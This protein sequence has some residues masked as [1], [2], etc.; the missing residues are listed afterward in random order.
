MM[1]KLAREKWEKMFLKRIK[2]NTPP[3]R[4]RLLNSLIIPK[5]DQGLRILNIRVAHLILLSNNNNSPEKLV[6]KS[7]RINRNSTRCPMGIM[8]TSL[9]ERSLMLHIS[10]AVSHLK[11]WTLQSLRLWSL[12]HLLN[13]RNSLFRM[14]KDH[15]IQGHP[16]TSKIIHS[17]A[18]KC[19][20]F[21]LLLLLLSHNRILSRTER[22]WG[23]SS[24]HNN[25]SKTKVRC[26]RYPASRVRCSLSWESW[27]NL[28]ARYTWSR[29]CRTTSAWLFPSSKTCKSLGHLE[30]FMSIMID[31]SRFSSA[32]SQW[33]TSR[34]KRRE[35]SNS[36]GRGSTTG[37]LRLATSHSPMRARKRV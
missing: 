13:N 22:E 9:K 23:S 18:S 1:P 36:S 29:F 32:I 37:Q 35:T 34:E 31:S 26:C 11:R 2:F 3:F 20:E 10:K 14:L 15:R 16:L 21:T 8:R 5:K 6:I 24:S 30:A 17:K 4:N 12:S 25:N 28:I 27:L 19:L 7:F 33:N